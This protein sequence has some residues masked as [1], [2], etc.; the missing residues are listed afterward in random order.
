M[1]NIVNAHQHIS[2]ATEARHYLPARQT[3]HYCM[4][5]AYAGGWS[6][7]YEGK[8]PPYQRDPERLLQEAELR[9]ADPNGNWTLAE[10]DDAGVDT[11]ILVPIDSDFSWGSSSDIS[12]EEKHEHIA[13]LQRTYPGRLYGLAG[14]D[15]RR[16]GADQIVDRALGDLGLHG[17]KVTPKAGYYPWDERAYRLYQLCLES[18]VPVA[19]CT[20]PDGGG[21][22]RDRFA[23]P[24]HV[25]D[26]VA[27]YPDLSIV[28][29]HGGAPFYHWLEE[30]ICVA[31]RGINVSLELDYWIAGFHP[32]PNL[33]P[34]LVSD[35]ETVV[36]LLSRVRDILGAHRIMWGS[37]TF[38]GPGNKGN[39]V[40]GSAYGFGL[41]TVVTWLR[42]LPEV[43]AR[44]GKVFTDDEVDSI[45]G[46]NARREFRL[47]EVPNW[48]RPHQF[49]LARPSPMPFRGAFGG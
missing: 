25:T 43:A 5:W 38:A 30:S 23:Q 48:V 12:I 32:V 17:L 13:G 46:E 3:W 10:M 21:Q 19:I 2:N 34:D 15:P 9:I 28:L 33:L 40:F 22:N 16:P 41:G 4:D 35:E 1:A 37:D 39:T 45:L 7:D 6:R 8:V 44:Y 26:V 31:G 42:N 11:S 27:D 47:A 20:G 18:D 29:L 14:P 24:I 49:G 36:I